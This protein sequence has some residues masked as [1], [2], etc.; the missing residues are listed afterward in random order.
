MG[1]MEEWKALTGDCSP[2]GAAGLVAEE[3][4]AVMKPSAIANE[5]AGIARKF[6]STVPFTSIAA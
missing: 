6:E 3:T 2:A 5:I 4:A 1:W